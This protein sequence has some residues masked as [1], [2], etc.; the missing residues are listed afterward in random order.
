[1]LVN[2]DGTVLVDA[3]TA[4]V[5][6]TAAGLPDPAFGTGGVAPI[7]GFPVPISPFPISQTQTTPTDMLPAPGDSAVLFNVG[8]QGVVQAERLTP[9]GAVDPTFGGPTAKQIIARLRRRRIGLHRQRPTP[10]T[11]TAG[12]EHR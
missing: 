2:A 9:S 5:R 12:A 4:V 8:S 3:T 11:A 7:T 6:Y 1:M 10:P